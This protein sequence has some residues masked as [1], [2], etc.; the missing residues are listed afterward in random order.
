MLTYSILSII[1]GLALLVWSAD[2]F[3]Y[4]AAAMAKDLGV[5]S[6]II[7]I[8]IV[9]FGTSAP[10]ML[11]SSMAAIGGNPG[12]GIGNAIGSNI[13]NILLILGVTALIIPLSVDSRTLRHEFPIL[14]IVILITWWLL[15]DGELERMN[16]ITLVFGLL[17]VMAW[18]IYDAMRA[19]PDDPMLQEFEEE[20]PASVPMKKAVFWFLLGLVVL[21]VSSRML[22][23]G[24]INIA[25]MMGISDLVIG[26]TIVAIG[27]S[28]PELAASIVSALKNESDLAVGNVIG[29]NLFN[30]LGVLALPGLIHPSSLESEIL[31]RDIPVMVGATVLL[32]IFGYGFRNRH[33]RINRFE[34]GFLLACFVAYEIMIFNSIRAS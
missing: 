29:S 3:I 11:V 31:S 8:T 18:L 10:E 1:A 23:W 33:G 25:E 26:L 9:G 19:R 20:I 7:G 22:V 34:G 5:S 30:T 12:L 2:R 16:G 21:L 32:F 13:A 17:L 24:A 28:L 27:T 4:G 6:M 14:L 15:S